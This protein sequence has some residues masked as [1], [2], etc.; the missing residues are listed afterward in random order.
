MRR[1]I[2]LST[3]PS[4]IFVVG[5]LFFSATNSELKVKDFLVEHASDLEHAILL[6]EQGNFQAV[7]W[8]GGEDDTKLPI[9]LVSLRGSKEYINVTDSSVDELTLFLLNKN[10]DVLWI[11]QF[12]DI[13]LVRKAFTF[14]FQGRKEEGY[15]T[16][17]N[18]FG[19]GLCT[20]GSESEDYGEYEHVTNNWY[21]AKCKYPVKLT[22]RLVTY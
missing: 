22:E 15:F 18:P 7:Q 8:V 12:H 3:V 6:A 21:I 16:F 11:Q 19:V 20:F 9:K 5:Y 10:L 4:I 14:S 17:G 2:A 13:W 1:L